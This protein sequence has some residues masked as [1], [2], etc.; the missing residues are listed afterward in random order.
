MTKHFP[1]YIVITAKVYL[2]DYNS[3]F[4]TINKQQNLDV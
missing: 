2:F 1:V 3:P 4:K